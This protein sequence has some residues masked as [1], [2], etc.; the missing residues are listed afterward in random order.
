M[1]E[2]KTMKNLPPD[3]IAKAKAAKSAEELLD[4]A[5]ANNVALTEEE[6]KSCFEQLNANGIVSDEELD[7][8]AGGCGDDIQPGDRV[9]VGERSCLKCRC[10][11]GTYAIAP[12]TGYYIVNCER[13]G[14]II[15]SS[16]D[17]SLIKKL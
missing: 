12:H 4:L 3:L 1:K 7:I 10:R 5:K 13:C 17:K 9:E 6:A 15:I 8:V 14:S 16:F 2:D 11:Y